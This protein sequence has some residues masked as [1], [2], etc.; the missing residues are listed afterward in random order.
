ML[1]YSGFGLSITMWNTCSSQHGSDIIGCLKC[2][3]TK[4]LRM[5]KHLRLKVW[6]WEGD[7]EKV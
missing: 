2:S 6:Q 7:A 4:D 1:S 5:T 3:F